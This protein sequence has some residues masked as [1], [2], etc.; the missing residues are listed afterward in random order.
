MDKALRVKENSNLPV[1]RE[2]A[3]R[4]ARESP[5]LSDL[6]PQQL[7]ALAKA[8]V[9]DSMK[10]DLARRVDLARIDYPA[11]RKTFLAV[12][13]RT[14]SPHT[15]KAY[16][17]ALDRLDA[18][19]AT[20]ALA[21]LEMKP[22]EA[23]DYCYA[24]SAEGRAPASALRDLAAAS[25]FFTWIE[26]RHDSLRNP[27]RGTK[28]RPEKRP[29]KPVDVPSAEELA[30]ILAELPP[31]ARA[32]AVVMST[33]GLRVG[34]LPGLSIRGGR[35]STRSKGKDL[36]GELPPE[37]LAAIKAASLGAKPFADLTAGQ[38]ADAFRYTTGKL[39]KAKKL[40]A[41]YS[42]HDLRHY[43]ALGE[44]RARPDLYR[45][46]LLLGHASIGVT[47]AYLRGLGEL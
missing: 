10:A 47:E 44:Y 27:F 35:F 19:A 16:S 14:R 11:E 46:K 15:R 25:S 3:E 42:V 8:V 23:D 5:A 39:F 7:E 33:R 22:R 36:A 30:A 4:I 20:R 2:L 31:L 37:A 24:L 1:V 45:L 43:Y 13:G 34:A 17:A 12:A 6:N 29:R 21:V 18:W 9:V 40:A 41:R 38:L 32:A 26:R 28:A